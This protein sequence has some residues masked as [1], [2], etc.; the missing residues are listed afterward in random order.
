[1]SIVSVLIPTKNRHSLLEG[2]LKNLQA[3]DLNDVEVLVLDNSEEPFLGVDGL[4]QNIRYFHSPE[5]CSVGANFSK[6]LSYSNSEFS[7]FIGDDDF[8]DVDALKAAVLDAIRSGSDAIIS[9]FLKF[10]FHKGTYIRSVGEIS[11]T[12]C[13]NL[14]GLSGVFAKILFA[15]SF[16]TRRCSTFW[17][18]MPDLWSTPKG[19]FGTFRTSILKPPGELARSVCLSPDAYMIGR[20]YQVKRIKLCFKGIFI[21][22]TSSSSTSGLSN[23]GRHVGKI[24][25]QKHFDKT[26]LNQL[27][28]EFIDSFVPENVWQISFAAGRGLKVIGAEFRGLLCYYLLMKGGANLEL[29]KSE[30]YRAFTLVNLPRSILYFL[31]NRIIVAA[32]FLNRY[33]LSRKSRFHA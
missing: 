17:I 11:A 29:P 6:A 8:V 21:P 32:T 23:R 16:V 3:Y 24:T 31:M 12:T 20:L 33:Y 13:F 27:P 14:E 18:L 9:P 4:H 26:D 5:N 7:C 19:Y 15:I 30:V 28:I 1:M 10:V 2:L 22:G 25:E